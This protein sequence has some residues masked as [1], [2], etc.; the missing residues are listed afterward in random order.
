MA[1]KGT[2][3]VRSLIL[4][5]L[6]LSVMC[7]GYLLPTV[8]AAAE[9]EIVSHSSYIET[10]GYYRIVGEVQ[11]VG[12]QMVRDVEISQT[13]YN[14]EDAV[15]GTSAENSSGVQVSLTNLYPGRKSPFAYTFYGNA[16]LVDHYS[17]AVVDFTPYEYTTD[18]QKLNI[19]S[20]SSSIVEGDMIISGEVEH[21]EG[22]SAS[23]VKVLATCYDEFGTVVVM[24]G[25]SAI[26]IEAGQPAAFEI[27]IDD[28][29]PLI[30][31]YELTT[32]APFYDMIPEFNPVL[33]SLIVIPLIS[34]SFLL[35]KRKMIQT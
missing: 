26:S 32:E 7:F 6:F 14:A 15:I 28:N 12:D 19:T 5:V 18:R 23:L 8:T 20:H 30:A 17:L 34:I 31:S 29:V 10:Y 21:I 35:S 22:S 4:S 11:N 1:K 9:I 3:V 33:L 24:G 25:Q 13:Y 27:N 16:S 2:F